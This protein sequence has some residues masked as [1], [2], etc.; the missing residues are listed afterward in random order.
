MKIL[1]EKLLV[2]LSS[3]IG[4]F[5]PGH[6]LLDDARYNAFRRKLVFQQQ[7]SYSS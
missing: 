1:L 7:S 3:V 2:I 6:P 4:R 5:S